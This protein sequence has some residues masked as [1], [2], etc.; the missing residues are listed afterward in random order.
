MSLANPVS[1]GAATEEALRMQRKIWHDIAFC[2]KKADRERAES[3]VLQVYQACS[4]PPPRDILW[5]DSP[6]QGAIA[7]A[8]IAELST[9]IDDSVA[10]STKVHAD[11]VFWSKVKKTSTAEWWRAVHQVLTSDDQARAYAN[12]G[13]R[14]RDLVSRQILGGLALIPQIALTQTR[15]ETLGKSTLSVYKTLDKVLR[16]IDWDVIQRKFILNPTALPDWNTAFAAAV[17]HAAYRNELGSFDAFSLQFLDFAHNSGVKLP[18][19]A[20]NIELA[21]S[22]GMGW[23]FREYC[24]LTDRPKGIGVDR[25]GRLHNS[26]GMALQYRDDWGIAAWHGTYVPTRFIDALKKRDAEA[27]IEERN[28]ELK[29][30]LIEA[31]GLEKFIRDSRARVVDQDRFGTLYRCEMMHDE[32]L[33]MVEVINSTPEPDGTYHRYFLRVPPAITTAR[34]A[35]AWTFGLAPTDYEP[36]FQS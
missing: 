15:T 13:D 21:K 6:M 34:A 31:Y 9:N 16:P 25:E 2:V 24:I 32:P 33:C 12:I 36:K 3:A 29:R 18:M 19:I 23:M 7:A 4:A 28:V 11:N 5:F 30:M 26:Q 14:A 17:A 35:V 10:P 1:L 22:C 20:G 8:L 27:I